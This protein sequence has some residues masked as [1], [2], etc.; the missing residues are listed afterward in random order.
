M[1]HGHLLSTA[2]TLL[3]FGEGAL[4]HAILLPNAGQESEIVT[5]MSFPTQQPC[6]RG[7]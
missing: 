2:H 7:R 6:D 1:T 4:L 3:L 5:R